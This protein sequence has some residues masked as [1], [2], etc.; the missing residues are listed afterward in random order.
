M[1][2][3]WKRSERGWSNRGVVQQVA[4]WIL[5]VNWIFLTVSKL[6]GHSDPATTAR[7]NEDLAPGAAKEMPN[8]LERF[9]FGDPAGNHVN[10]TQTTEVAAETSKT[11]G[12]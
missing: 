3:G 9:V 10:R 11:G 2:G 1:V 5:I 8:V 12:A 6:L 7:H 4:E